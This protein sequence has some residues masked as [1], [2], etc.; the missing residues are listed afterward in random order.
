VGFAGGEIVMFQPEEE[1]ARTV[2]VMKRN[3]EAAAAAAPR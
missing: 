2:E 3:M 1:M